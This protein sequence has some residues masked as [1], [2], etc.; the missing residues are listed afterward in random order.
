MSVKIMLNKFCFF[1]FLRLDDCIYVLFHHDCWKN[2]FL[3]WLTNQ[4]FEKA[5]NVQ[6]YRIICF[7]FLVKYLHNF[8]QKEKISKCMKRIEMPK[9]KIQIMYNV[10]K[11][12]IKL[13]LDDSELV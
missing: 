9:K 13:F 8:C 10:K 11:H 6:S 3:V 1:L 7:F 5:Q 4:H 12:E 2:F